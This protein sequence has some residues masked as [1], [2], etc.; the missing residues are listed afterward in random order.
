MA[1]IF[2]GIP[3]LSSACLLSWL[4]TGVCA[5][6]FNRGLDAGSRKRDVTGSLT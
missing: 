3:P 1:L 4:F 6:Q 5:V 2:L